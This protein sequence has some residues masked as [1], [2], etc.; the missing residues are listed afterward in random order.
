MPHATTVTSV[1]VMQLNLLSAELIFLFSSYSA[2]LIAR[3]AFFSVSIIFATA[4]FCGKVPDRQF[5]FAG[6]KFCVEI[7]D[8]VYNCCSF[9]TRC[10]GMVKI[11]IKAH[12]IESRSFWDQVRSCLKASLITGRKGILLLHVSFWLVNARKFCFHVCQNRPRFEQ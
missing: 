11:K 4:K 6:A 12:D 7:F 8:E 3:F 1:I 2:H 10:V 9:C 5:Q